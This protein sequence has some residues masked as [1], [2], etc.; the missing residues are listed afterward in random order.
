[1]NDVFVRAL[2]KLESLPTPSV[3]KILKKLVFQKCGSEDDYSNSLFSDNLINAPNT[4]VIIFDALAETA[5]TSNGFEFLRENAHAIRKV[6]AIV[7]KIEYAEKQDNQFQ[8]V[9][10]LAKHLK[11]GIES[12]ESVIKKV[13]ICMLNF[14]SFTLM[15]RLF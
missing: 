15:F 5:G 2:L 3:L 13:I 4:A 1:M 12:A 11:S 10:T 7:L 8:I 9:Q 6:F 14:T